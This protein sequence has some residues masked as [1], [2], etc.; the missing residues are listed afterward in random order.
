ME[1]DERNQQEG[2]I[3]QLLPQGVCV[4]HGVLVRW[5]HRDWA[6]IFGVVSPFIYT[7]NPPP[8]G[9]F[10][11]ERHKENFQEKTI[12]KRNFLS[13]HWIKALGFGIDRIIFQS[14]ISTHI[15]A[16]NTPDFFLSY[17]GQLCIFTGPLIH[18]HV[19]IYVCVCI[20]HFYHR[21]ISYKHRQI[22]A[23]IYIWIITFQGCWED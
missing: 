12:F 2:D 22:I 21:H 7:F 11:P 8:S 17:S 14:R 19:N 4:L 6:L 9:E 16:Q 15:H 1:N 10:M 13:R 23:Y 20:L 18:T 5:H 3:Q